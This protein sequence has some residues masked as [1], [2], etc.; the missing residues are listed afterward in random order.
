MID[1][2]VLEWRLDPTSGAAMDGAPGFDDV[3][4]V[5]CNEGYSSSI[6]ARDLQRLGF[7]RAT[8]LIGGFRQYAA[9]G[10]PVVPEPT[11]VVR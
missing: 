1:R 8:D 9:D 7:R 11:R 10:H 3:I 2:L 5:V 4:V 6:A